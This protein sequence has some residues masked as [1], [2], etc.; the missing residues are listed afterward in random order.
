MGIN[1]SNLIIHQSEEFERN[2]IKQWF[3][4]LIV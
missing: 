1:F 4:N 2:I 3:L